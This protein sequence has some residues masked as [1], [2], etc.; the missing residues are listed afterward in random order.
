M[1]RKNQHPMIK[2]CT[3]NLE[4]CRQDLKKNIK[5]NDGS[6]VN[7]IQIGDYVQ[8]DILRAQIDIISTEPRNHE[9][10]HQL[11]T[12]KYLCL[13][14]DPTWALTAINEVLFEPKGVEMEGGVEVEF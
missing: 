14:W 3:L 4:T 6:H 11:A 2:L 8:V 10:H 5:L 13:L 12:L 7:S 9:C 1:E